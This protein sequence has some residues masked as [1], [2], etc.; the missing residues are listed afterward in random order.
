MELKHTHTIPTSK[1]DT[2]AALHNLDILKACIPGCTE[3]KQIDEHRFEAVVTAAIGP[4]KAQFKGRLEIADR[5]PPHRYTLLFDGQ[6]GAAGFGKGRAEV[7]LTALDAHRTTLTYSAKAQV[8]GKL[9]QLGA[10]VVD[11]AA[12]K[13]AGEFFAAFEQAVRETYPAVEATTVPPEVANTKRS[14]F[15]VMRQLWAKWFA[16]R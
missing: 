11:L 9:A 13:M 14:W 2:W 4:V 1:P 7:V 15:A 12:Q 6:S 16:R 8:G 10:R 3:L 5:D